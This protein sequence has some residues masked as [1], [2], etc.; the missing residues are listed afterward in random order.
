MLAEGVEREVLRAITNQAGSSSGTARV[1]TDSMT[2]WLARV[3]LERHPY[4]TEDELHAHNRVILPVRRHA[5]DL[6]AVV[7]AIKAKPDWVLSTNTAHWS[8]SLAQRTGLR[9]ATPGEFLTHLI[10]P[11]LR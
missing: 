8:Q 6:P 10:P 7:T 3:R 4:P 11:A 9:I 2:G 1:L 5:N